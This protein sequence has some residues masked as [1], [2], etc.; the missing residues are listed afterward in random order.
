MID[1]SS[2]TICEVTIQLVQ[3]SIFHL[4]NLSYAVYNVKIQKSPI[5]VRVK[6]MFFLTTSN[7][8]IKNEGIIEGG[9]KRIIQ[10]Y[11]LFLKRKKFI[12]LHLKSLI[13]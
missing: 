4:Q 7:A 2:I 10:R 3:L 9:E 12:L 11:W 6:C 1:P 5:S 13:S 8:R